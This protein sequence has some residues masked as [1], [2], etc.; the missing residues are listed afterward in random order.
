MAI[1]LCVFAKIH[2]SSLIVEKSDKSQLRG[3]LQNEYLASFPQ[4]CQKQGK[5]EKLGQPE[6]A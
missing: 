4:N 6:E 1:Y 2:N 3:I 5:S